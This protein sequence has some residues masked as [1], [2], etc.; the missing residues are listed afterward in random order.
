MTVQQM[1]A[2]M[3]NREYIEWNRYFALRRQQEELEAQ[4]LKSKARR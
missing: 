4:K 1:R 3:S 2:T